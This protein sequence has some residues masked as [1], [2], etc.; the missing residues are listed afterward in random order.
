L[1]FPGFIFKLTNVLSAGLAKNKIQINLGHDLWWQQGEELG[2]IIAPPEESTRLRKDIAKRPPAFQSKL[3]ASIIYFR[4][5]RK[6]DWCFKL[7][8]DKTFLRS[9]IG[10]DFNFGVRFELLL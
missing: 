3:F 8:G 4:R 2:K 5:G 7:Y 1:V 6:Y 9:G 10:K